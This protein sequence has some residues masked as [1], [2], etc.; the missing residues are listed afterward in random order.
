MG[1]QYIRA[2][3]I[4]QA[5]LGNIGR[6]GGGIL[7]LRGHASIQGSTDIPT[8]FDMLPGYIPMPHAHREQNLR[9]SSR[10]TPARRA[11]GA[12]STRTW[13]ACS[14]PGSARRRRR[15][16]TSASTTSPGSPAT[17]PP[18]TPCATRSTAG[19]PATS[20][21]ARTRPSGTANARQQRHGLANLEW[22]VVRDLHH[23]RDGHLLEGR[24]GDRHRRA[25]HRGHRHRGLLPARGRAHREGRHV[26]QHPA[27]AAVAPQGRRA[28]RRLPQRAVVLLRARAP[29][30]AA[31]GRVHGT[32]RPGPAGPDLGLPGRRAAA[33]RA[34]TRSCARST[35]PGRTAGRS[36]AT[37]R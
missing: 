34:R 8:L 22:L 25:A 29:D 35:A 16:T 10:P 32:A 31:A 24:P 12:T 19:C 11:S 5:L 37:P 14:R 28:A 15:R 23:D 6:P 17:T 21:S 20:W 27:A 4:L 7:A 13:S 26:H 18:S 30:Q 2:A 36:A 3:S 9:P 1:A 33:S